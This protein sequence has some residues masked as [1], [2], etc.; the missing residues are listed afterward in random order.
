LATN[1]QIRV[2][3]EHEAGVYSNVQVVWSTNHEI[4][5]DFA[6]TLPP[7]TDSAG[8]TIVPTR[9]VARVKMTPPVALALR[10]A[11][12][13]HLVAYERTHGP[14]QLPAA[15]ELKIEI[16]DDISSLFREPDMPD[17]GDDDEEED[18]GQ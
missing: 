7:D 16:P 3:D 15:A 8:N 13:E 14:I 2:P 5:I 10:N 17:N 9:V 11:V 12:S 6:V 4:T 18:D 1:F